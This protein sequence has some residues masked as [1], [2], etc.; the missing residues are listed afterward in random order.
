MKMWCNPL[1][2]RAKR[3]LLDNC[4]F[5]LFW[6]Q[7]SNDEFNINSYISNISYIHATNMEMSLSVVSIIAKTLLWSFLFSFIIVKLVHLKIGRAS[8]L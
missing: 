2:K 4:C 6:M 5:L 1:L 3:A 7:S 8:C